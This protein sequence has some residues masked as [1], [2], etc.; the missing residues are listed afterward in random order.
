MEAILSRGM[1][2][3]PV[4]RLG[5]KRLLK[6]R[7]RDESD[8]DVEVAQNRFNT[9]I[10]NLKNSPIAIETKE[11]NRQHY[12]L[13]AQFFE[14]VMG[15]YLKYSSGYWKEETKS[16]TEAEE[17]ML[18]I[19]LERADIQSGQKILDLG[20]GWGSFSL[21]AAQAYPDSEFTAISNSAIQRRFI[22]GRISSLGIKN[23]KV[24]TQDINHLD[25]ETKFDRI[26][27][28]E[29][30]E[31][32]RNYEKLLEKVSHMMQPD[33][34]LFVH[35]FTHKTLA[36][37]FEDNDSTDFLTR[38]FFTGGTMPSDHLL[39]YFNKDLSVSKHWVVNGC[40]YGKTS[41]AWLENM[42]SHEK[43]IMAIFR[44]HYGK[45]ARRWWHFW[46]VFFMSCAEL[47]N[48]ESGNQWHV[49]HYLFQKTVK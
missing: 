3:E 34:K 48:F 21:F 46:K 1:V 43:D 38:N 44:E 32:M 20:C 16:L 7:I 29:M 18:K 22:E 45:E 37:L 14:L 9:L 41:E 28:I 35:I 10:E 8:S 6:Q 2:P 27:S 12:E 40:H 39:H 42:K 24:I 49:S 31:H 36:Y 26:I 4:V 23:L 5:I 30:F 33:G 17:A 13:P 15:K 19:Y 25:L 11:A 47:W